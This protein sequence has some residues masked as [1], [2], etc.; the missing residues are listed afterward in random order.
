MK[1]SNISDLKNFLLKKY[2]SGE[3][4]KIFLNNNEEGIEKLLSHKITCPYG[5]K[6]ADLKNNF[7]KISQWSRELVAN[8]KLGY[9]ISIINKD[10][11][12]FGKQPFPDKFNFSGL[13]NIIS[14]IGKSKDFKEQISII[15]YICTETPQLE[16]LFFNS[17]ILATKYNKNEWCLIL[18]ICQYI[19]NNNLQECYLRELT[20]KHVHTKFIEQNKDIISTILDIILPENRINTEFTGANGFC[21]RYGFKDKPRRMR[22]RILDKNISLGNGNTF[23]YD[24]ELDLDSFIALNLNFS[25]VIIAENEINFLTLPAIKGAI[26]IFGAGYRVLEY[27]KVISQFKNKKI[28]YWGDIDPNGLR[29]LNELK[30]QHP[31]LNIQSIFMNIETLKKYHEFCVNN[32]KVA[33]INTFY[34]NSKEQE[35]FEALINNT[36]GDNILL[37]QEKIPYADVVETIKNF[38]T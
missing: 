13:E 18:S 3:I 15:E 31:H 6:N 11:G 34:L 33:T 20:I 23:N 32:G 7:S 22:F 36:M 5:T 1:I 35:L 21:K 29:I 24:I 19:A 2:N 17:P 10:L 4:F 14:F 28:C 12:L 25:N 27:K 30:G 26:G 16:E 38:F 9:N 8:E 37:E